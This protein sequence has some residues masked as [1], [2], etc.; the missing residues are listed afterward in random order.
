MGLGM[1]LSFA[2]CFAMGG[3]LSWEKRGKRGGQQEGLSGGT[4]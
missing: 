1:G 4:R 2:E 3:W